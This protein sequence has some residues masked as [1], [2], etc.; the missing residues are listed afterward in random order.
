MISLIKILKE[1][2][3]NPYEK[4]GALLQRKDGDIMARGVDP[5][6]WR[7]VISDTLGFS[8]AKKR[9]NFILA[10]EKHLI[11]VKRTYDF[12]YDVNE[13]MD[14]LKYYPAT[15][16]FV[17]TLPKLLFK[18]GNKP[19]M[20]TCKISYELNKISTSIE[21]REKMKGHIL[22]NNDDYHSL[23]R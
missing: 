20:K 3:L 15:D 12:L 4:L 6:V 21:I 2:N 5:P 22:V 11:K 17:G 19:S 8:D 9:H 1:A 16:K 18:T 10:I 13:I 14:K 23:R 7:V